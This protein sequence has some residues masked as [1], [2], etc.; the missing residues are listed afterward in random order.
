MI[1]HDYVGVQEVAG[2]VVVD[3][4]EEECGVTLDLEESAAI[5]GGCGDEVGAGSW[6]CGSGSPCGGL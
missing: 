2:T 5:M 1:G 6:R 3:G 4:F